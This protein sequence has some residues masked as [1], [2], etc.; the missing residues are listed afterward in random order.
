MLPPRLAC[1]PR[2]RRRFLVGAAA[3]LALAGCGGSSSNGESKKS[4]DQIVADA[5]K[6]ALAASSV[7]VTGTITDNGMPLRLDMTIVK[8]RGGKGTLSESGATF[9]LVRIGDTAYLRGSDAFLK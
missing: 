9:E 3:V 1:S 2:M 7:H 6:A 8:D 4:A 5:Q